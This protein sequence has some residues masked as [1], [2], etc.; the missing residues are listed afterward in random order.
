MT[1]RSANLAKMILSLSLATG[2]LCAGARAS[3]QTSASVT[4]PF[5]FSADNQVV[6]AGHYKVEMLS[7]RYLALRNIT[8]HETQV[9]MVRPEA[10][11]AIETRGR[12]V[13][14][15]EGSKKYLSQVWIAGSSIHSEM[16]TQHKPERTVAKGSAPTVSNFEIAMK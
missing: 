16:A 4:I 6:I 10:G 2:L 1:L 14:R 8:T 7:D 9:L 15:Q 3:A 5:A 11:W 13:F 12:L